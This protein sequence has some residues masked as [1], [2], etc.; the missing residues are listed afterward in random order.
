MN[1]K[2]QILKRATTSKKDLKMCIVFCSLIFQYF[3]V[4]WFLNLIRELLASEKNEKKEKIQETKIKCE[5]YFLLF[6]RECLSIG[7]DV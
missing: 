7:A 2:V 1:G 3:I 4:S 6:Q 5:F